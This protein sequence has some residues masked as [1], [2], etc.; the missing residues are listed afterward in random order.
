LAAGGFDKLSLT[1]VGCGMV[2]NDKLSLTGVYEISQSLI[3]V[4]QVLIRTVRFGSNLLPLV[5][6]YCRRFQPTDEKTCTP[7]WALA[8]LN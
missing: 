1:G 3:T 5:S 7:K 8:P 2:M 6:T 4:F